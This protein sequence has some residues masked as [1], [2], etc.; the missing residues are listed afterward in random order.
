MGPEFSADSFENPPGGPPSSYTTVCV[1]G[2]PRDIITRFQTRGCTS[3]ASTRREVHLLV[4]RP[5]GALPGAIGAVW[6]GRAMPIPGTDHTAARALSL[7]GVSPDGWP[8]M[9]QRTI[10]SPD[11]YTNV[12]HHPCARVGSGHFSPSRCDVPHPAF[13]LSHPVAATWVPT[14]LGVLP[15][16]RRSKSGIKRAAR[17][18][19]PFEVVVRLIPTSRQKWL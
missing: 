2:Q 4:C 14:S 17:P 19:G 18:L 13:R 10:Y 5:Y 3:R 8:W 7:S 1:L 6:P 15:L 16:Y 9:K 11:I 12:I